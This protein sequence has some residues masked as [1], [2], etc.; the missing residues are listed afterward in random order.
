MQTSNLDYS[1]RSSAGDSTGDANFRTSTAVEMF[2]PLLH[3]DGFSSKQYIRSGTVTP[4]SVAGDNFSGIP[5]ELPYGFCKY[6]P[7]WSD[8]RNY[9]CSEEWKNPLRAPN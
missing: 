4:V 9:S 7:E 5:D 6:S 3:N 1:T 2:D 8:C